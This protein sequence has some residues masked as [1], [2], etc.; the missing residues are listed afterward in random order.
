[1]SEGRKGRGAHRDGGA[2][3]GR[4]T[5]GE[6]KT[7]RREGNSTATLETQLEELFIH[8]ALKKKRI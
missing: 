6:Q 5:E 4:A 2:G 7:Q 8:L 3:W 1:M